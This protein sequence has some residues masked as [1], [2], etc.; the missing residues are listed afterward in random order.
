MANSA[1]TLDQ[2]YITN[3]LI[4]D[5]NAVALQTEL[6]GNN[7]TISSFSWAGG[8][9]TYSFGLYQYDV[10]A[11]ETAVENGTA[12]NVQTDIINF[13]TSAGFNQD[14]LDELSSNGGLSSDTVQALSNQLST[15][16]QLPANQAAL[17]QLND[18]WA[19]GLVSQL[20]SALNVIEQNNPDI[21]NQIYQSPE[22]QLRLLDYANQFTLSSSGTSDYMVQWL[23]GQPVPETGGTFQL[24]PGQQLTGDDI[25]NF[26]INTNY[27]YNNYASENNRLN[28][29]DNVLSTLPP[30]NSSIDLNGASSSTLTFSDTTINLA[31]SAQANVTGTGNDFCLNDGST[32]VCQAPSGTSGSAANLFN[33]TSNDTVIDNASGSANGDTFT[34]AA[35]ATGDNVTISAGSITGVL[36]GSTINLGNSAQAD[37]TGTGNDFYLNDG[38]SLVCQAPSD[39]SGSAANLFNLTSNDTVVDNASGSAN[40]DTFTQAAGA[41]GDNVTVTGGIVTTELTGSTITTENGTVATILGDNNCVNG[42]CTVAIDGNGNLITLQANDIDSID[43]NNNSATSDGN[44][45][46]ISATGTDN[47]VTASDDDISL[48]AS[49]SATVTGSGNTVNLGTGDTATV[50]GASENINLST[51]TGSFDINGS[52]SQVTLSGA[53]DSVNVIGTGENFTMDGNSTIGIS[54]SDVSIKASDDTVNLT[55]NSSS[56]ITGNAD[57]ITGSSSMITLNGTGNSISGNYDALG[58]GSGSTDT[59]SSYSDTIDVGSGGSVISDGPGA[60]TINSGTGATIVIGANNNYIDTVNA[61]SDL[62]ITLNSGANANVVGSGNTITSEGS[63][64]LTASGDTISVLGNGDTVTGQ[65][66]A[67]SATGGSFTLSNYDIYAPVTADTLSGNNNTITSNSSAVALDGTGNTLAGI[68]DKVSLGN[69]SSVT[70]TGYADTFTLGT[71]DSLVCNSAYGED[72]INA[73][74]TDTVVLGSSTTTTG[75]TINANGDQS[76][77]LDSG[78]SASVVGSGNTITSEGSNSL[79]ASGDTIS[80]LGNGDTVTGQGNAISA[81]GESLTLNNND[82]YTTVTTDTLSGNNNT[83]TSSDSA[84]ALDGTGNTLVGNSN[85]ITAGSGD[86]ININGVGDTLATASGEVTLASNS[87]ITING[88]DASI[89]G[90][91]NDEAVMNLANSSSLVD[92]WNA[93]GVETSTLYADPNGTGK[94]IGGYGYTGSGSGVALPGEPG[95]YGSGGG[96]YGAYGFADKKSSSSAI[97]GNDIG[98]IAQ[99]DLAQGNATAAI[100]AEAAAQQAYGIATSTSTDG[101]GTA[102]LEGAKWDQQVITWSLAGSPSDS[103]LPFSNY[104]GSNYESA[105]QDAFNAWA[106]VDPNITF[107]EVADSSQSD[108]RIGFSNFNTSSSG[109]VGYTSYQANNGQME[110]GMTIEVEDPNQD[111]LVI[112]PTGQLTYAGTNATLVQVL[113]HEIGHALGFADN[114]DSNSIM[115][116]ELTS[117]N[118]TL[119]NTDVA[120]LNSLYGSE[121]GASTFISNSMNQL[122]QAMATMNIGSEMNTMSPLVPGALLM[123]KITLAPPVAVH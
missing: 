63:N 78:A 82:L 105:V 80:V 72:T 33:L 110:A 106:A 10:G 49:S 101:T 29:L 37:V 62:G 59:V 8:K 65:G 111:S 109:V 3:T 43:G 34:Q 107:K 19:N 58:I 81:T 100:A 39:T 69:D 114:T 42:N 104:M 50:S 16:L 91:T 89:T 2:T 119:D 4:P 95:G 90:G 74:A 98:V 70:S 15:A 57:T 84:V 23:S 120:G 53:G 83:I 28:A 12:N 64:N 60:N 115:Y 41:T 88:Y 26:V 46:S 122:V 40:G 68:S 7:S 67:I 35:G 76:I 92:N 87:S 30:D 75:N 55:S 123:N 18:Q 24:T 86:N 44:G 102:V 113:E 93:T 56:E 99:Y 66:N 25:S 73:G 85:N 54:G 6:G 31:D 1:I 48:G 38:S 22:L 97:S 71:N 17:Q 13:L 94:I 116:Y 77:T 103:A 36:N 61:S 27:G 117:S 108:I 11:A 20:Q 51:D 121:P 14:Q 118:A 21:A 9:S 79:T 47:S 5:L 96:T 52:S 32:L 45:A 112:G